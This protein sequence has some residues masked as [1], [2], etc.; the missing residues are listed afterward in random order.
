MLPMDEGAASLSSGDMPFALE[1][2]ERAAQRPA[3]DTEFG[4]E[5]ALWRDPVADLD[6]IVGDERFE[7]GQ[8]LIKGLHGSQY[9]MISTVLQW[10]RGPIP[11]PGRQRK[12]SRSVSFSDGEGKGDVI[13]RSRLTLGIAC[14]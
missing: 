9:V 6:T 8:R 14:G 1:H 4:G 10:S 3:T 7:P 2:V 5:R 13:V 12:V 11:V